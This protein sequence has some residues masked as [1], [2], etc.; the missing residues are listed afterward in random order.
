VVARGVPQI[1]E[2]FAGY[3]IERLIGRGGMGVVCLAEHMR[4]QQKRALELLP[5]EMADDE[6]FRQRF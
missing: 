3:R 4:L 6:G 2:E 1:G 5:P